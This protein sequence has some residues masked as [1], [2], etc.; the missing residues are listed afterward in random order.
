ML[1][2]NIREYGLQGI[3]DKRLFSIQNEAKRDLVPFSLAVHRLCSA[4]CITKKE[5]WDLFYFLQ[6]KKIIEIIPF[7]GIKIIHNQQKQKE[8]HL[9]LES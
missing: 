5:C 9:A 2:L 7:H 6:D 3:L 8:T 1:E 4:F